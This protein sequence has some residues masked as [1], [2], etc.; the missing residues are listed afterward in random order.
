MVKPAALDRAGV[1]GHLIAYQMHATDDEAGETA[2]DDDGR[3]IRG[4]VRI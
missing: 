3:A 2:G 4:P 1:A